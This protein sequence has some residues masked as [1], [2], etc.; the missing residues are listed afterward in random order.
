MNKKILVPLGQYDR[1]EEMIPYIENVARPG[2]KVVFLVRYPVDGVI[3]AKRGVWYE[4]R[5][6]GKKA[7]EL[8]LLGGEPRKREEASSSGMRGSAR[9]RHRNSR[10]CLRR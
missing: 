5:Y 10:G 6:G 7:G 2:M 9:Q 8:L 4:G 1:S 3:R